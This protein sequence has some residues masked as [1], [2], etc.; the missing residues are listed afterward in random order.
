MDCTQCRIVGY[1]GWVCVWKRAYV[2]LCAGDC[3]RGVPLWAGAFDAVGDISVR[4]GA[5][6]AVGDRN[7]VPGRAGCPPPERRAPGRV[8][9]PQTFR[10]GG[11]MVCG[12]VERLRWSLPVQDDAG[13]AV[14]AALDVLDLG[15]G[16]GGE[17]GALG[18]CSRI[19]RSVFS[20]GSS[21]GCATHGRGFS[22]WDWMC[23]GAASWCRGVGDDW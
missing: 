7:P 2:R 1:R 4:P 11:V 9:C 21:D 3:R 8:E 6:D 17:A 20:A 22:A 19:R 10:I 18:G 13:S 16:G 12:V 14:E 15:V 5:F 23:S